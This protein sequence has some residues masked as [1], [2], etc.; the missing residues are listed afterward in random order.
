MIDYLRLQLARFITLRAYRGGD[1]REILIREN[2]QPL[3]EVPE[4]IVFSF[5]FHVLKIAKNEK[6]YLREEV[7][8]KI[9]TVRETLRK[10]GFDLKVYDGW[11]S[12]ELQENLFW[13]YMKLFTVEKFDLK[14]TFDSLSSIEDIKECYESLSPEKRKVIFEANRT[15]V[16][17]PTSDL[18]SPSPHLTGGSVDIWL[19]K[20][21]EAENLG[22]PFDW[23]KEDAG[24]FYHLKF[25]RKKFPGNDAR[26]CRNRNILLASMIKSG[27]TYYGPEVWHFNF[28]NQMDAL[29]KG[30]IACYSYLEP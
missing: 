23:M 13:Y 15:Y 19:Y 7:L 18:S 8:R 1:W 9:L 10:Q 22:V 3:V 16:S 4:E 14:E 28:G 11:R 27:F 17:W 5:Y 6:L 12:I 20:E 2:G 29:V 26:I 21:G 30:G 24:A 25:R